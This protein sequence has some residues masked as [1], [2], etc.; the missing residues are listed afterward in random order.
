MALR[1]FEE[2]VR[3]HASVVMRVCRALLGPVD[4]QDAWSDTFVSALQ[5]YPRLRSDSDLRAWLVTIAHHKAIDLLRRAG[6]QA[7]PVGDPPEIAVLDPVAH[8]DDDGLRAA[9]QRLPFKQRA[10]VAYRYLA[11]LAYADIAVL[12]DSSEVAARR[13]AADGIA[14][15]RTQL[16]P[17]REDHR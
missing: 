2:V 5:A 16:S 14:A 13:S 17:D 4:A 9:V 3:E 11:D 7:V 15:L 8:V 12:L 1:P 6:R 10:A